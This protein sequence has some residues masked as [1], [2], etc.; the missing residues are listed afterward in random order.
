MTLRLLKAY[1]LLCPGLRS[2]DASPA[3]VYRVASASP[4][5]VAI[6]RLLSDSVLLMQRAWICGPFTKTLISAMVV[7]LL[8]RRVP[9][10]T[11]HPASMMSIATTDEKRP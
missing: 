2:V 1:R 8:A 9:Q 10:Y 3:R 6:V 5:C 4:R 7:S 11:K